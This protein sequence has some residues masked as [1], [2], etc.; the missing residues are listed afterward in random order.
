LNERGVK[1]RL[2]KK[3]WLMA[4]DDTSLIPSQE[5]IVLQHIFGGLLLSADHL[6]LL[7]SLSQ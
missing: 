6:Q 1:A 4:A 7:K 5:W 2:Q 3:K